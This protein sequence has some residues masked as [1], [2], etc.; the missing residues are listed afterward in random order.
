M[1]VISLFSIVLF[2]ASWWAYART[3][4]DEKVVRLFLG[5]LMFFGAGAGILGLMN[6]W[7]MAS[8]HG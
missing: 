3:P 5:I 4:E 8:I 7:I 6:R 1:D 2:S